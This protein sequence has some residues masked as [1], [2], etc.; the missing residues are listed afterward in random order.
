MPPLPPNEA[1]RLAAL[2]DLR[3]L[4]TAPEAHFDAVCSTAAVLFA[5]PI[6]LITF[7]ESDR[8]WF[9]ARC[10]ITVDGTSRDRAFCAYAILA[11]DVLVVEDATGDPRFAHNPLVTGEPGIRFYAGAPL[12]L[13]SGIRLGT[14]CI[15]DTEPRLF[16]EVQKSQLKD[17]AGIVV[18]H[19]EL[20][21]GRL[22][23]EA[24]LEGG[25][26]YEQRITYMARHDTLTGLP[27]RTVFH[28]HLKQRLA[29]V[30][31]SQGRTA[32]LCL[33][34]N[35]FR[36]VNDTLGHAAGDNLLCQIASR[37]VEAVRDGDIVARLGGDEFAIIFSH[38]DHE[39]Q[40]SKLAR[41]VI[42]AVEQPLDLG[43]H[44]VTVGVSIGIA[45]APAD[46]DAAEVLFKNADLAL[47]RAKAAAR[48]SSCFYEAGMDAT[49][50]ARMRLEVEMREAV[51]YGAFAMHYQPVLRLADHKIVGFEALMR[52]PHP[53]RGMVAPDMFIP[54]AEESGMIVPLGSWALQ[55]A[56]REAATWPDDL[57]IAVNVSAVQFQQPGLEQS[58][59]SALATSGLAPHRL[60]LEITES[61]LVQDAE[62]VIACLHRLKSIGVRIA[63]DDFGTG[64]SSLSYLRRFPFDTIKIDRSFIREIS[65]P[66]A[67]AIVR[68]VVGIATQLGAAVTAEGVETADQLEQVHQEG[69]TDV[70]GYLFSRPLSAEKAIEFILSSGLVEHAY[71]RLCEADQDADPP[72]AMT[73]S[74]SRLVDG[75]REIIVSDTQ[76][77]SEVESLV[78]SLQVFM[79]GAMKSRCLASKQQ[80]KNVMKKSITQQRTEIIKNF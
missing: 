79:N 22:A 77:K 25:K 31:R 27:N 24:S 3:I 58:V 44:L 19:I 56:C 40:A 11:D 12:V 21:R 69:C 47:H 48:S 65:D 53:T 70:Q 4:D 1:E 62:A 37:L 54:L 36:T 9:K 10:G 29:E 50:E 57:R 80:F 64:Y 42:D 2:R 68:A 63:L 34:L 13:G 66:G 5:V 35:R 15:I 41:R 30:Q 51:T 6:A 43:G 26:A 7:I 59:M 78:H 28:E 16:S 14:L 33:G 60:V 75:D 72:Q 18:A 46:G 71:R 73:C 76:R 23:I 17:L 20:H 52:W 49:V 74:K 45:L 32:L 55:E 39:Y 67:A 61:V 38:L 8:Q